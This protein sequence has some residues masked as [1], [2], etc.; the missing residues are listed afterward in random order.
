[1]EKKFLA[2][3]EFT[4]WKLPHLVACLNGQVLLKIVNFFEVRSGRL[5]SFGQYCLKDV[6]G[7]QVQNPELARSNS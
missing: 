3:C 6:L 1:M 4:P 7:H 2:N 5:T